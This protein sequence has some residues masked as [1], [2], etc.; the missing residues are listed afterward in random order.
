MTVHASYRPGSLRRTHVTDWLSGMIAIGVGVGALG[1]MAMLQQPV[2]GLAV[3][4]GL[5]F[6]VLLWQRPVVIVFLLFFSTT[7]IELFEVPFPDAFTEYIPIW[8]NLSTIGIAPIPVNP[9]ELLMIAGVGI[10]LLRGLF[11]RTLRL[12]ES[13]LLRHYALYLGMVVFALVHGVA[14]GGNVTIALWEVRAPMYAG[15]TL[16]LALNLIRTKQ[17]LNVLSWLI[18][19]GTGFKSVQGTWRYLVTY[20]RRYDGMLR[21]SLLEH[22]EAFFFP[23]YYIFVLLLLLFDGSRRQKQVALLL[24]PCVML[25]DLANKRRASTANLVI[26]LLVLMVILFKI[27]VQHRW[28]IVQI[29]ALG[30]VLV[31]AYLGIFWNSNAAIAQPARAIRSNFEPDERDESSDYYRD[32]ENEGLMIA[33][34]NHL[35]LGQG[36]GLEMP[37]VPGMAD[38]RELAPFMLYMP[39]N[40]ILWVWWRTGTIGFVLFWAMIGSAII[41]NCLLARTSTDPAIRRWSV[42][43]VALV[44]MHLLMAWL[45]VG[46]FS[47][48]QIVYIWVVLAV[49]DI[50][51]RLAERPAVLPVKI[52]AHT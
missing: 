7:A 39:H 6:V 28:R 3:F 32:L 52:G 16:F 8:R 26:C 1:L 33:I 38:L 46:L 44:V 10:W 9:A 18:I 30:A 51:I 21:N 11:E 29:A 37:L 2:L 14:V 42:F 24:L 43:A 25:A 5:G 20:G 34:R 41:Q 35:V 50:L 36:Y 17:Q 49:P 13:P 47:Y 12:E 48:R 22:D 15:I 27:L 40:S 4:L 19:V 45:D 31:A 23:A